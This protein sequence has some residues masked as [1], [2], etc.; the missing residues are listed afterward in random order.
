[1]RAP[2]KDAIGGGPR[3]GC[4]FCVRR[5]VCFA[6]ED[7]RF[8]GCARSPLLR[9][10]RRETFTTISKAKD[11][12][13]H[14]CQDGALDRLSAALA[15]ARKA[16]GP[17]ST[18]LRDLAAAHVL[19]VIGEVE[20]ASAHIEVDALPRAM[21]A[22]IVKKCDAYEHGVR[23]LVAGGMR[24]GDLRRGDGHAQR[25]WHQHRGSPA[26]ENVMAATIGAARTLQ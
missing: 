23:A 3:Y 25:F 9:T 10:F 5:R 13:L 17:V 16:R 20:G 8:P 19:C 24:R 2:N 18:R 12:I 15:I 26:E 7:T 14:F 11:E 22:A 21:R 1:V 6:G 4:K